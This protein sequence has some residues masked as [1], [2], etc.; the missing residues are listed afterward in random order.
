MIKDP[1]GPG[2]TPLV[3]LCK[4]LNHPEEFQARYKYKYEVLG[5]MHTF[6][7]NHSLFRSFLN[8]S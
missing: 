6:M 4:D 3:I 2:A 5:G 8:A 1:A 7:A